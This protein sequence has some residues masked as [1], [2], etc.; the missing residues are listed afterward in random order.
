MM[1]SDLKKRGLGRGLAA[2]LPTAASPS[3]LRSATGTESGIKRTYFAAQIEDVYPGPEQ[4]RHNFNEAELLELADSIRVH[5]IIVPLV[6]RPR[7]EGG[8][9]FLIAGER[10]WRAAQRAG[11]HDVPVVV[12]E[13][14]SRVAFERALVENLQ[15]SDL[16]AIEEAIA[17]Q[18][19]VE[20]FHLTQDQIAE[21]I[22][23]DRST[24]SNAIR[25]LKLPLDVRQMVEDGRLAMGNARALLGLDDAAAISR[26]AR[27]VIDKELTVR[28]TENLVKQHRAPERAKPRK[29]SEKSASVKDL[30]E[31]LT[32]ALGG[33]VSITEDEP[34]KAGR[35]EIKYFDLDHLD[36]LLDRLL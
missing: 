32:K 30:E 22:G 10:R 5:G 36:R 1:S 24:I 14:D 34:G 23:K 15:R 11:L 27:T 35:M 8:G 3:P 18:R 28:A 4:P 33:P 29:K 2:L 20:E 19:L 26:F 25:L 9:Y 31:R 21:H 12:Q 16:S 13:V 17:F 6:V 7:P